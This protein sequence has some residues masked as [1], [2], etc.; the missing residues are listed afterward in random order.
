MP[1]NVQIRKMNMVSFLSASGR[2]LP[3]EGGAHHR[4]RASYAAL[5]RDCIEGAVLLTG[6]AFH[7]SQRMNQTDGVV[8][9]FEDAM[10]ANVAAYAAACAFI[11]IES[12]RVGLI[13]VIHSTPLILL[14]KITQP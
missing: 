2:I 14:R 1:W 9:L 7:T 13:S 12:Q 8:G 6:A 10:R 5:D 3:Q 11:R 4:C